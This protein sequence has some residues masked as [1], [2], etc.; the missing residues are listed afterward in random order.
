[1]NLTRFFAAATLIALSALPL[2]VSAAP[3]SLE[4]GTFVAGE[5]PTAGMATIYKLDDGHRVLRL[6]DFH[7]SNGPAV[8]VYLSSAREIK[9]N[10]DV[11]SG[12]IIDLGDLK[13]NVGNQNYE[14]P[15]DVDLSQFHSVSIWCS[16]FSVNFGAAQL[17]A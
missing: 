4:S 12:K 8:H 17:H 15:G 1:V 13:G 14:L 9:G 16:R 6:T 2:A 3:V 10:G 7:T 11:T 5:H